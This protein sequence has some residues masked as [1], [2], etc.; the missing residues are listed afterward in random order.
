MLVNINSQQ[1]KLALTQ[2][3]ME[4]VI[5]EL[6]FVSVFQINLEVSV[7]QRCGACNIW[8]KTKTRG[9]RSSAD[10]LPDGVYAWLKGT[11][12]KEAP[13]CYSQHTMGRILDFHNPLTDDS[14][15]FLFWYLMSLCYL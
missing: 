7:S 2:S 11:Q 9:L 12:D 3:A 5:C 6:P 15:F 4:G 13:T 8:C 1:G 14:F 10:K